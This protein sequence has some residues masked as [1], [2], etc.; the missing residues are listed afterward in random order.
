MK[1]AATRSLRFIVFLLLGLLLLW[2]AFRNITIEELRNSLRGGDYRWLLLSV[3]ASVVAFVSRARRWVLLI[4]ALDYK[5]SLTSAYHS[6]MTGYLANLAL[7]RMGEVTRCVALGRRE[8]IPVDKLIGTVVLERAID[9]VGLLVIIA[10]TLFLRYDAIGPFLTSHV[11]DPFRGSAGTLIGNNGL[12]ILVILILSLLLLVLFIFFRH[13]F[14]H[15]LFYKRIRQFIIGIIQGLGSGLLLRGRIEFLLH[16]LLIWVCWTV[17]TWS[18]FFILPATSHLGAGDALVILI[19]GG[20]GMTAPVQSGLGAFHWIVSRAL[21]VIYEI[22]LQDA[23]AYA[24]IS[25]TS[26]MI[27]VA[28]AGTLSF[29]LLLYPLRHRHNPVTNIFTPPPPN[30]ST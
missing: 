30:D 5:P 25:H 26:Q 17:M 9:L 11:V 3:T 10:L 21:N 2:L 28:L 20:L 15:L 16:T 8:K 6:L 4:E 27:L 1:K 23:L 12:L 7:P 14:R 19:V 18:V 24:L 22:N 13:R 29:I